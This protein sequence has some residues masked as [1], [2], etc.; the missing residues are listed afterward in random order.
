[1]T[2]RRIVGQVYSVVCFGSE[3]YSWSQAVTDRKKGWE[4]KILRRLSLQDEK[5]GGR[6]GASPVYEDDDG[7]IHLE[8]DEASLS[9]LKLLLKGCG[10]RSDGCA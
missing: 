6:D 2:C 4:T 1:M 3:N 7:K 10:G 9:E 5:D 8:N